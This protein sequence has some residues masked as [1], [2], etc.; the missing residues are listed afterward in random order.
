MS[1]R[2]E[3]NLYLEHL[4]PQVDWLSPKLLA[5]YLGGWLLLLVAV[6]M[7]NSYQNTQLEDQ[8]AAQQR[9]LQV[10]TAQVQQL[11]GQLPKS[12]AAELDQQM[13]S[14]GAE[15]ERRRAISR[16]ISGQDLGNTAGF[17]AHLQ[18]LARH[19]N[20]SLSLQGFTL[21]QGGL[22]VALNGEVRQAQVLPAFLQ[23]LQAEPSF[24]DSHFGQL[25]ITREEQR[26]RFSMNEAL[27]GAK[28]P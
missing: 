25:G 13:K 9:A 23:A 24:S 17:S 27:A 28:A 19:S 11:K 26:L 6:V 8:L 21:S 15:V 7:F 5:G 22:V 16:L 10:M 1:K 20:A 3:V 2:Q 12:R 18:G 4:R 14:L